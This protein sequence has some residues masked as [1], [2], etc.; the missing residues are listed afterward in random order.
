MIKKSLLKAIRYYQKTGGSVK[1]FAL[2]CNFTPTCSEYTHQAIYHY[3]VIKGIR[4]G[5]N[6]MRRCNDPDC[7][8]ISHDPVPNITVSEDIKSE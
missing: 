4:L 8:N 3:G 7:V 6:R 5:V 2:S 1:H